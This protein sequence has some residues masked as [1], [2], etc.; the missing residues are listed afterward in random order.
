MSSLLLDVEAGGKIVF[1]YLKV[2]VVPKA[3]SL[4]YW[5][6]KTNAGMLIQYNKNASCLEGD[7]FD[8]QPKIASY[9]KTIELVH[10]TCNRR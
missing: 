2:G 7:T 10:G 8:F 4:L 1:P 5:T 6:T 3:G 9:L